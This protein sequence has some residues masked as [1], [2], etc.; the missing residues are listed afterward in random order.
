MV[1]VEG[2]ALT[3]EDGTRHV[4]DRVILAAGS[5]VDRSVPGVREHA[6]ALGDPREAAR[7][8]ARVEALEPGDTVVVV[9]AGL[10]GLE[11]ATELA[12]AHPHLVVHLIGTPSAICRRAGRAW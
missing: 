10:T 12:E 4:F 11:L 5:V 1:G 8:Y 3:L 6:L 2:G 7:I 9:G